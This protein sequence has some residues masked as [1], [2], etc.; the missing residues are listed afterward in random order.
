MT[1]SI[2]DTN[3]RWAQI[4]KTGFIYLLLALVLALF[5]AVYEVFSHG[6]YSYYMLYAFAFPLAGGA[7]PFYGM[8]LSHCRL[9]GRASRNL[10]H[11]GIAA[12]TVGSVFE[13]ILEIYGTTNRLVGVYWIV[14]AVLL[15]CGILLYLAGGEG[16]DAARRKGGQRHDI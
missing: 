1:L 2:S 14:G 12:L 8:A 5:G 9:P 7:L 16:R 15:A 11:S 6:V 3:K 4:A 10:Y 13:G